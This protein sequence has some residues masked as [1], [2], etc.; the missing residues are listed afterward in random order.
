LIGA[1]CGISNFSAE[2]LQIINSYRAKGAS[3]GSAG[4][5]GP[6]SPLSW[7]SALIAA[8]T[9]HT[10]DM[11]KNNFVSHIG[12]DGSDP[13]LRMIQAGYLLTWWGENIFVGPATAQTAVAWWMGSP[14][15]CANIMNP[16][17]KD[18]GL[19]C[20]RGTASNAWPSYWTMDVG[21]PR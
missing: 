16:R 13:G 6:T 5:Y 19:A 17:Y 10:E 7:N 11:V 8:A 2:A 12:S 15:H 14:G 9:R 4:T 1:N 18:V 20:V 3:C 21:Q